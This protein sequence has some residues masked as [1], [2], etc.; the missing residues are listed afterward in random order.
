M[1]QIMLNSINSVQEKKI[2]EDYAKFISKSILNEEKSSLSEFFISKVEYR[3][4]FLK[5]CLYNLNVSFEEIED[6]RCKFFLLYSA[7]ELSFRCEYMQGIFLLRN[8][9]AKKDLEENF[10]LE[11]MHHTQNILQKY[12]PKVAITYHH[13]FQA[14]Y[15]GIFILSSVLGCCIWPW[16][17]G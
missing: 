1:P 10:F 3:L 17:T 12:K 14:G 13:S 9:Y 7:V 5:M 16:F 15:E 6:L 4:L 8:S 11:P 2:L